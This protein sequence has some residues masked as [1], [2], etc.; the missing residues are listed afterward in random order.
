[1]DHGRSGFDLGGLPLLSR[2][3]DSPFPLA[4]RASLTRSP[5]GT[6]RRGTFSFV[7]RGDLAG[8]PRGTVRAG[9]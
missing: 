2:L 1:L 7:R 9:R 6:H 5:E 3:R 8:R 4:H